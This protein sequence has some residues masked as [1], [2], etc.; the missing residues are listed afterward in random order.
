MNYTIK[1]NIPPLFFV[2]MRPS[3]FY[4]IMSAFNDIDQL[5]AI[6]QEFRSIGG[7]AILFTKHDDGSLSLKY[8]RESSRGNGFLVKIPN[9]EVARI[10]RMRVDL[11]SEVNEIE[12]GRISELPIGLPSF[13]EEKDENKEERMRVGD[14]VNSVKHF[15]FN[16]VNRESSVTGSRFER[17]AQEF[18]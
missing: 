16:N 9:G 2:S 4:V 13:E 12:A 5:P 17:N 3:T 14:K 1:S 11:L 8:V 10:N 6:T 15:V 18:F 7:S